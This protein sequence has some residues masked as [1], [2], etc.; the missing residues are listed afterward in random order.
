MGTII[1]RKHSSILA[2][3]NGSLFELKNYLDGLILC[4]T[5]FWGSL[6][7][8]IWCTTCIVRSIDQVFEDLNSN[9][10]R[11]KSVR[12]TAGMCILTILGEKNGK[13]F[14]Q[15]PRRLLLVCGSLV[16]SMQSFLNTYQQPCRFILIL[17]FCVEFL[18]FLKN[19][20]LRSFLRVFF[21]F[22]KFLQHL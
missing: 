20:L 12:F 7:S 8:F 5:F 1:F 19:I 10:S 21:V 22:L 2:E 9:F 15:A 14:L 4:V 18:Q 11:I 3:C 6:Y 16:L 17:I 13:D